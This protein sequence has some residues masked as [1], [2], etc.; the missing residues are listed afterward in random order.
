V[1]ALASV[2]A[3][4]LL[5]LAIAPAHA[6]PVPLS[7]LGAM[8]PSGVAKSGDVAG[9]TVKSTTYS[10]RT[11]YAAE[12]KTAKGYCVLESSFQLRTQAS[13]ATKTDDENP[14][15]LLHLGEKDGKPTLEKSRLAFDDTTGEVSASR[16]STIELRE[17]ARADG[18]AAWAFRDGKSVVVLARGASGGVETPP[19]KANMEGI[20][21]FVGADDCPYAVAR[22]DTSVNG[23]VAQ[24]TGEIAKGKGKERK[25]RK[26]FVD[27]SLSRVSRDPEPLLAVR[28]RFKDG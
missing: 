7:S 17:V 9:I 27:A 28:V 15:F 6:A 4:A 19:A 16:A 12:A 23:A 21:T 5:V 2:S 11:Y 25:T 1:K 20:A 10:T 8:A 24:L 22:L 26:F 3:G 18:V 14:A 13:F